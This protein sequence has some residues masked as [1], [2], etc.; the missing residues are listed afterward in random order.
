M[1]NVEG[2]T[3]VK[4]HNMLKTLERGIEQKSN[5]VLVVANGTYGKS[6]GKWKG[7]GGKGTNNN[8]SKKVFKGLKSKIGYPCYK[9]AKE[10][11][12]SRTYPN[13]VKVSSNSVELT[14]HHVHEEILGVMYDTNDDVSINGN[15]GKLEIW[16][17]DEMH[18]QENVVDW[19]ED[20]YH[21]V[22]ETGDLFVKLNQAIDD[23]LLQNSY[24][25]EHV[26]DPIVYQEVDEEVVERAID[27]DEVLV[28]LVVDQ[29]VDDLV[30]VLVVD[31]EVS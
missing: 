22:D 6:K 29:K 14:T 24:L 19:Q 23:V 2:G 30:L 27:Q 8:S 3:V 5:D 7:R 25:Q 1:N 4:L 11:H 9:Y 20:P 10:V 28:D 16:M 15:E 12:W 13:G 18:K 21:G 26:V 17:G 31:Q